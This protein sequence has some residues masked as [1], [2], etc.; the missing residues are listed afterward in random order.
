MHLKENETIVRTFRHHPVIFL[1]RALKIAF[2][3]IP[4]YFLAFVLQGAFTP[5]QNSIIFL[6][7][8]LVFGAII[9]YDMIIFYLD[10][11]IVTNKRVVHV[12]WKHLFS[13]QEVE[14]EFED[15]QNIE[16]E[17]NGV[18]AILPFFDFGTL[19]IETASSKVAIIFKDAN[20]PEGIKHFLYR[21][22]AKP[23]RIV[24]G[25]SSILTN[26]RTREEETTPHL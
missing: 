10:K 26:D 5:V 19:T 3:S 17:E 1:W 4:F 12:N 15:I 23:S 21:L 8:T 2:V 6:G 9:A 11:L 7:I 16:T 13:N 18:L 22:Q 25:T 20:D 24:P 14:V